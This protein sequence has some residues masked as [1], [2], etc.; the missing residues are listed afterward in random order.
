M[1][2]DRKNDADETRAPGGSDEEKSESDPVAIQ[3]DRKIALELANAIAECIT[4]STSAC[5]QEPTRPGDVKLVIN[6]QSALA[7][8]HL[9]TA[10]LESS[11]TSGAAEETREDKVE[12]DF[13]LILA[14]RTALDLLNAL[15]THFSSQ[16]LNPWRSDGLT[17]IV[18]K[19]QTAFDLSLAL[20]S[21]LG[22]VPAMKSAK[23]GG[24]YYR[25]P[26][27]EGSEDELPEPG[28]AWLEL[29]E[30]LPG[31]GSFQTGELDEAVKTG[32]LEDPVRAGGPGDTRNWKSAKPPAAAAAP[33][34]AKQRYVNLWFAEDATDQ[35]RIARTLALPVGKEI[36]LRMNIGPFDARHIMAVEA[37]REF[38]SEETIAK[39]FPETVGKPVPLEAAIFS[40]HFAVPDEARTQKFELIG[41]QPT[42]PLYFPVTPLRSGRSQLRLC[43]FYRNHLLQSLAITADVEDQAAPSRR[44]QH[45]EVEI[46]FSADFANAAALPARGLWLG[47]NQSLDDTHT[48]NLKNSQ[49]ALSRDLE[50]KIET[51]LKRA[52]RALREVSFNE[53]ADPATGV[54]K[55]VYRFD[56]NNFPGVPSPDYRERFRADLTKLAVAGNGLYQAIFGF[57]PTVEERDQVEPVVAELKTT[58]RQEQTI[59]IAR[60]KHMEDIWPWALVYDLPVDPKKVKDVCLSFRGE[61]GRA[62]PYAE[63]AERCAH[64]S[65]DETIVCPYRFWGFKHIIE[66]PTQPGGR[67]AF[68]LDNLVLEIKLGA[69]PVFEMLLEDSL[70]KSEAQHVDQ[71]KGLKFK[72]LASFD[73]IAAVFNQ[74]SKPPPAEPHLMYFFCH[75][76]SDD[77]QGPY[78]SVG[79]GESLLPAKLDDW[80]FRWS[81]S[82]GLVFINGCHTVDLEPAELSSIMQPFVEARASGIIGTEISITTGLAREFAYEFFARFLG[83]NGQAERRVGPIIRDLRLN[84]LMKYNPLGLVYTP[85]CS[86][87]LHVAP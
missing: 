47:I 56:S 58:L 54:K 16:L 73:E 55:K 19:L 29:P 21:G 45:V 44:P 26:R 40:S 20:M 49:K 85:Y 14:R 77:E 52:R 50:S 1:A 70:G 82:H 84:L 22:S 65:N 83:S 62:L 18:V 37:V 59:Q 78:L 80:D 13:L 60:L 11:T 5:D 24:D 33:P 66:Q 28:D 87:D 76:K 72:A 25:G 12:A 32:E 68:D 23:G 15:R 8:T 17:A 27:E 69:E 67:K 79:A 34:A 2:D 64:A 38:V 10:S 3:V 6:S 57:I 41:G 48:L 39:A 42:A 71:M 31:S 35:T 75:G 53:V 46:T 7:L 9:L 36:Y 86:A 43:V 74:A 4:S 63:G 30:D 81:N 51:A 61:H